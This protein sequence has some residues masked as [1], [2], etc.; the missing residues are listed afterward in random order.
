[1][2][3]SRINRTVSRFAGERQRLALVEQGLLT[4][5]VNVLAAAST[6]LKNHWVGESG[7]DV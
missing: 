7:K 5:V 4:R 1:M 3:G 6:F 2:F